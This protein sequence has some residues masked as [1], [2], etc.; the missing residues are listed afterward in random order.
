MARKLSQ[1]QV[2]FEA[3]LDRTY[4]SLLERGLQSPTLRTICQ[5]AAVLK[6]SPT[7]IVKR[8]EAFMMKQANWQRKQPS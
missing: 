5:L 4:I 6:I 7:K 8:T 2:G 1:E 3:N